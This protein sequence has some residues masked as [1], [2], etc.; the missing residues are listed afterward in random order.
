MQSPPYE[1]ARDNSGPSLGANI[2]QTPI[3]ADAYGSR[4]TVQAKN[5]TEQAEEEG[6]PGVA[7]AHELCGPSDRHDEGGAE[8]AVLEQEE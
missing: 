2:H 4:A 8:A 1:A 7:V 5:T 6:Q 3:D